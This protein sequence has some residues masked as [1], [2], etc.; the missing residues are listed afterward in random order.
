[1]KTTWGTIRIRQWDNVQFK[2]HKFS[3]QLFHGNGNH[4]RT[5][6]IIW[7]TCY[8]LISVS[9]ET[10]Q[11]SRTKLRRNLICNKQRG[12]T[13]RKHG[14]IASKNA[15]TCPV[16]KNWRNMP[17]WIW[18][19]VFHIHMGVSQHR[20]TPKSSIYRRIFHELNQPAIGVSPF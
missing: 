3:G 5:W 20:R 14:E 16:E 4:E 7:A 6:R 9:P 18:W 13:T 11:E 1:M 17:K 12:N 8:V 2:L 10:C 15:S 19:N